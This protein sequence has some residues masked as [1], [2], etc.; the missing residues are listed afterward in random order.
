MSIKI[1]LKIFLFLFLFLL[2]SQIEIY[3]VLLLFAIIHELGHLIMGVIL[4]FRPE[5]IRLTPV[6]LQIKF[7]MENLNKNQQS[8]NSKPTKLHNNPIRIKVDS[9]CIKK[10]IIALAGPI[11]NLLIA[12]IVILIGSLN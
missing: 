3:I 8:F 10:A 7:K 9:L 11:T 6:G 1:D 5:E 12:V 4:G 2:T